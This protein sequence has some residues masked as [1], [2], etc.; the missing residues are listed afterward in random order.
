MKFLHV[1]RANSKFSFIPFILMGKPEEVEH[2]KS[3]ELK[4]NEGAVKRPVDY[5][6]LTTLMNEKLAYFREYISA[7]A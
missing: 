4:P 7:L 1:I 5:E 3:S 6:E 2:L